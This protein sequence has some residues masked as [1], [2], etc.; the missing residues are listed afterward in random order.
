[1]G[2]ADKIRF[3][4][5]YKVLRKLWTKEYLSEQYERRKESQEI[6]LHHARSVKDGGDLLSLLHEQILQNLPLGDVYYIHIDDNANIRVR[7]G[8]NRETYHKQRDEIQER[9]RLGH[10]QME[11][12]NEAACKIVLFIILLV[13]IGILSLPILTRTQ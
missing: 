6:L 5:T 7:W 10:E 11:R 4:N 1:M 2:K 12:D 3:K 9:R 13:L 8:R